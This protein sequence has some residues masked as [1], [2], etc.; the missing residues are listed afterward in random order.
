MRPSYSFFWDLWSIQLPC[1]YLSCYFFYLSISLSV[2]LSG[3]LAVCLSVYL[4]VSLSKCLSI[5]L[6]I[7]LSVFLSICLSFYLST[8]LS[9][10]LSVSQSVCLSSLAICQCDYLIF[11]LSL[12]R[13]SNYLSICACIYP[14]SL[15]IFSVSLPPSDFG[16]IVFSSSSLW[17]A[18]SS[19]YRNDAWASAL[20]PV[21]RHH[22]YGL[23]T[24][25]S[26]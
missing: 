13:S 24:R 2:C 5:F 7:W 20:V 21:T 12:C 10:Y 6:S 16:R 25:I 26:E 15:D 1:V 8:W 3:W 22:K 23:L 14:S 4:S 9:L 19:S 17:W 11:F 18:P